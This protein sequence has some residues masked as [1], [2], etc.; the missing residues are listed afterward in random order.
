[1][2]AW[3]QLGV[4]TWHILQE[5]ELLLKIWP[6]FLYKGQ[7]S[8]PLL[9]D[10]AL[11]DGWMCYG[12]KLHN[13]GRGHRLWADNLL[14]G[15]HRESTHSQ[16]SRQ[17]VCEFYWR[18]TLDTQRDTVRCCG[19]AAEEQVFGRMCRLAVWLA[20]HRTQSLTLF[21]AP[22]DELWPCQQTEPTLHL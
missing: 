10:W 17:L 21:H 16:P 5:I 12:E 4:N 3:Y 1:M 15:V 9:K 11:I 18:A 6:C 2:I 22:K 20:A 7:I 13:T 8:K 14:S 19:L